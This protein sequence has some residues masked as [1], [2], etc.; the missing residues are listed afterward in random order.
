MI[1]RV[2]RFHDF[3]MFEI[4][5]FR[6]FVIIGIVVAGGPGTGKSSCILSLV[7][8]LT[9]CSLVKHGNTGCQVH[10]HKLQKI[11]PLAVSDP[12][13]MFG[14]VGSSGDWMDGIFTFYWKKANKEHNVHRTTTW[15]CL[16][17]P[18]HQA[19]AENLSSVLDNG[20]VCTWCIIVVGCALFCNMRLFLIVYKPLIPL[21]ST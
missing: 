4:I 16:D 20:K 10:T 13:L 3:L 19:W 2:Y 6:C 21:F 9:R 1:I 14:L 11:N 12:S 5:T 17:A 15:L 18:L 8:A 7:E